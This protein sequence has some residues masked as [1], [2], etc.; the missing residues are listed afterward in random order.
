[1][2]NS[3]EFFYYQ[4]RYRSFAERKTT[5]LNT[6][7]GRLLEFVAKRTKMVACHNIWEAHNLNKINWIKKHELYSSKIDD[8]ITI[9]YENLNLKRLIFF[10]VIDIDY[11]EKFRKIAISKF[12]NNPDYLGLTKKDDIIKELS[13][14][15]DRFEWISRGRLFYNNLNKKRNNNN[16]LIESVGCRYIKTNESYFILCFEVNLSDFTNKIFEKII[17][18]KDT[19]AEI[20]QYHSFFTIITKK[21]FI[22]RYHYL[23]SL[24]VE[25]IRNLI[26][27]INFQVK[28]NYTKYFNGYF[29]NSKLFRLLPSIEYYEVNDIHLFNADHNLSSNFRTNCSTYFSSEDELSEIHWSFSN[30]KGQE[31]LQVVKQNNKKLFDSNNDMEDFEAH[32]LLNS[33]SFSCVF[34]AILKEHNFQL[35]K[36]KRKVYDQIKQSK[37]NYFLRLFRIIGINN[38]YLKLKQ[39][40]INIQLTINRFENEFS[41]E[42][43]ILYT[44]GFDLNNFKLHNPYPN[45]QKNFL[46]YSIKNFRFRLGKLESGTKKINEIFKIYEE[47]NAYKT[48]LFL[49]ISSLI[50][51]IIAIFFAFDKTKDFLF[52]IFQIIFH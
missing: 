3:Q 2:N 46:T 43:I 26:R 7:K 11:F 44:R 22:S 20:P 18:Q 19:S 27:D 51:A 30:E 41:N 36:L 33:L 42:K 6:N 1:M 9:I 34:S 14:M 15:E 39:D 49:Q 24:K 25:N 48:N 50:F 17:R 23:P 31:L 10:E 45:E 4:P 5:F 38:K 28:H 16:D 8:K 13:N 29:H 32:A 21:M 37:R 40:L 47:Y 12:I 35:K 52:R